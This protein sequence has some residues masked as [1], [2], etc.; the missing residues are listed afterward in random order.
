MNEFDSSEDFLNFNKIFKSCFKSLN[1][2]MN[3]NKLIPKDIR[4]V[5][6]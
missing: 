5:L 4:E 2:M 3:Y 1:S 6:F